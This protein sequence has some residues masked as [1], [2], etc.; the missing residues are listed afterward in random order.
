[1]IS[2]HIKKLLKLGSENIIDKNIKRQ[3]LENGI[4][5]S[6]Q[7]LHKVYLFFSK[8]EQSLSE[9]DISDNPVEIRKNIGELLIR[10]SKIKELL[11]YKINDE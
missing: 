3:K 11:S 6:M 2:E 7:E 5:D 8:N 4:Y 10:L 9:F 1:M